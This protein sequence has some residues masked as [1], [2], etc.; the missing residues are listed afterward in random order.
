MKAEKLQVCRE[1]VDQGV[2]VK[3]FNKVKRAIL[4]YPDQFEMSFWFTT[5]LSFDDEPVSDDTANPGRCGTAACMAGWALSLGYKHTSRLNSV[6]ESTY[7]NGH[8]GLDAAC[9]LGISYGQRHALFHI[10][11]WP[12]PFR[13]DYSFAKPTKAGIAKRAKV[14]VARIDHFLTTGE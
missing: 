3:L 4:K 1:L 8:V 13:M 14:A 12:E 5:Q 10:G 2:N 9:L 7:N 11:Y 6:M